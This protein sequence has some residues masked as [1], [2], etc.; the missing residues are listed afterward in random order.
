MA[1]PEPD[2]RSSP[3][4]LRQQLARLGWQ[5]F[6]AVFMRL[7]PRPFHGWRSFCLRLWGA[8]IGA[9]CRIYPGVIIWAP[10]NLECAENACVGDGAELYNPALISLGE[11]AIVSQGAFLCTASHDY[12]KVLFPLVAKAIRVGRDAWIGARAMVLPGCEIGEGSVIG[13]GS[14]VTRSTPP[15]SV[16]AGNPC[17]VVR[18]RYTR[19]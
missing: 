16:C 15:W 10:W 19:K 9:G 8:R 13:L 4:P 12:E 18:E 7:S 6:C 1:P 17:R 3:F 14:V 11:R 2:I 5:T